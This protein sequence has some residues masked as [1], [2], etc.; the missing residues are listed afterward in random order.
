MVLF[1]YGQLSLFFNFK[2]N[3]KMAEIAF[4]IGIFSYLVFGLGL[5]SQL[6]NNQLKSL[7]FLF[8]TAVFFVFYKRK[9]I[10]KNELNKS[11]SV[12]KKDRLS[13]CLVIIL[14]IA[15]VVNL[16][17]VLG[18]ELAF[19]SLW[20]HLTLPKL[21]L[22]E[23]KIFFVPG[24]L[25]YYSAMPKLTELFYLASLVFSPNGTGAKLIHFLFGVLSAIV[26]FNLSRRYLKTRESLLAT[27]I[28]Y[29]SLV[30]GWESISAYVDLS[31][32][33]FE[34]LA[35]DLFLRWLEKSKSILLFEFSLMLGLAIN[36]K[37]IAFASVPIYIF[38]IFLKKKK[39]SNILYL[40]SII[41]FVVSPWL[42]YS[43]VSTG[44]PVHPIFSGILDSHHRF[45]RINPVSLVED[46][47]QL[48]Y[49]P[50]DPSSP[51]FLMFLPFVVWFSFRK[52]IEEHKTFYW[53][54][55]LALLFW[56]LTPK[57]G[58]FRFFLPY[59]PALSLLIVFTVQK[60]S[61]FYQKIFLFLVFF[62][63]LINIGYRFLANCKFIPVVFGKESRENFLLENLKFTENDFYDPGQEIKCIVKDDLV[64]IFGSHNLFYADFRY[65]HESFAPRD[66]FFSYILTQN[67]SLDDK[68][69]KLKVV[70]DNP[71]TKV[72]LYLYGDRLK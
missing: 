10:L 68:Y 26:L 21:F 14:T 41:L 19:D 32:T 13:F 72:K 63:A 35:L 18:P 4:I 58:G 56:S 31:R 17:G 12:L 3:R 51:I 1:H 61:K 36:T 54:F 6:G 16:I 66:V 67:Y 57:T 71:K 65:F 9:R 60:I 24:G 50:A 25:F 37:L 40:I 38:L 46:I 29:T 28:F 5:L 52:K 22:R 39:T 42:I 43:L 34:L 2:R 49:H 62:C 53:Y 59:L 7:S 27:V 15:A 64:L 30:V 33:F 69:G 48:F 23:Q 47:W 8:L 11:I 20:Y 70:Y 45:P 55:W 44:N